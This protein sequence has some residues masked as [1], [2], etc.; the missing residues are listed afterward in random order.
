VLW[1]EG[2]APPYQKY[3][4]A[5]VVP[6]RIAFESTTN[7][8]AA[9]LLYTSGLARGEQRAQARVRKFLAALDRAESTRIADWLAGIRGTSPT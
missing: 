3:L 9:W 6:T 2:A 4:L 8:Y 1:S 7:E 5:A